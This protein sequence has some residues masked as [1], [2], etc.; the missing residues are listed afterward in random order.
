[1]ELRFL[2]RKIQ[3]FNDLKKSKLIEGFYV[4]KKGR[5]VIS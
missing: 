3:N 1:M 4:T 2:Q 5:V